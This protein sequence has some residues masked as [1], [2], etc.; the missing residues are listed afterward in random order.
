MYDNTQVPTTE[1]IE[2]TAIPT[3]ASPSATPTIATPTATPTATLI[4]SPTPTVYVYRGVI[5]SLPPKQRVPV[6]IDHILFI[7]IVIIILLIL[8]IIKLYAKSRLDKIAGNPG[9]SKDP[10]VDDFYSQF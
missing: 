6:I 9:K 10:K 5:Q 4:P 7:L 1:I 2:I 8:A 3:E